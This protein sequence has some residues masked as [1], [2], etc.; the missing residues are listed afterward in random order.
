MIDAFF[1]KR[2]AKHLACGILR[3]K[4]K[5]DNRLIFDIVV[6]FGLHFF[7][8]IRSVV[9]QCDFFGGFIFFFFLVENGITHSDFR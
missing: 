3:V 6:E 7:F 2:E 1:A 4:E 9:R 8:C 5:T